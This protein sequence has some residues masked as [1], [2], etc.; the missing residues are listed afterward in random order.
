MRRQTFAPVPGTAVVFAFLAVLI[1]LCGL[2]QNN[3]SGELQTVLKQMETVGKNFRSFSA[4]FSQ[5]KYTAVLKEFDTPE[6]G[7]F[8]YARAKDG[9]A[10]L[11]KEVTSPGKSILTIKGEVATVYQPAIKQAQVYNLGKNKDKAEYLALGIGQSPASLMENFNI[12]YH[13]SEPINGAPC[14]VLLLNPKN[15]KAA[16]FFSAITLWIKKTTGVS[17]QVKLQEPSNDY[18]LINFLDEKLNAKIPDSKFEQKLPGGVAEQ[19]IR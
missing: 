15:P 14:S 6:S 2:G 17:V 19:K 18:L 13:G 16:A 9:S 7:E 5:K 8:Y 11:R 12:S 3:Q 4:R 10:L 1:P